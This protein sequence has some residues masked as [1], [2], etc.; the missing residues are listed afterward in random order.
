MSAY[1]QP[2]LRFGLITPLVFN[3]VLLGALVFGFSKLTTIRDSKQTLYRE[4]TARQAAIKALEEK[5]G[6]Q[7]KQFEEQKKLLQTDPGPVFKQILD[8]VLPK[9][10]EFELERTNLV[11]PLERGRLGKMVQGEVAR[12][13]STFEGG[14]GPMQETLLQVES[15][16][17][18]AQLEEIKIKRKSDPLSS[19]TDHLLIDTIYTL[20]KAREAKK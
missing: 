9:Y 2:I 8:T 4:Y 13:K 1:T 12:V 14:M 20:W 7:R 11:F 16:M 5:L 6:P 19:R 10:T 17:P 3:S 18:Q 15:L